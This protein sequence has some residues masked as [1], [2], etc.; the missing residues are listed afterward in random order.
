MSRHLKREIKRNI[1]YFLLLVGL[2]LLLILFKIDLISIL[3]SFFLILIGSFSKI[4]KHFTGRISLGFEL[5]TPVTF[6]FAYSNGIIFG[7]SAAV[8]MVWFASFIQGKIDVPSNFFEM[9][10]YLICC[11]LVALFHSLPIVPLGIFIMVMRIA[12]MVPLGII[13]MGRNFIHMIIVIASNIFLNVL[14][15]TY[16]AEFLIGVLA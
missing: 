9:L 5:I 12:I 4:Y 3:V 8:V 1:I 15:I 14:F 6:I 13:F 10:T 11:I 16:L 2:I 7:F